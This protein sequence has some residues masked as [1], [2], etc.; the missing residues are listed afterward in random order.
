MGHYN[1]SRLFPNAKFLDWYQIS[2]NDCRN[3]MCYEEGFK[4]FFSV[5]VQSYHLVW[6]IELENGEIEWFH[7]IVDFLDFNRADILF[8]WEA[9]FKKSLEDEAFQDSW[10]CGTALS[11]DDFYGSYLSD[12]GGDY[13]ESSP[14]PAVT[15]KHLIGA[16]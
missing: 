8:D 6:A 13:S 5:N 14:P 9:T 16:V 2:E 7:E 4:L 12:Y 10:D 3:I 1:L 11:W 15:V